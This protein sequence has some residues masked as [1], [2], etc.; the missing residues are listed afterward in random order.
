[1]WAVG[2]GLL[3]GGCFGGVVGFWYVCLGWVGFDL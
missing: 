2:A 1:M 3:C